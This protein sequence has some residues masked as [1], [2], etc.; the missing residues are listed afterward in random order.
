[1]DAKTFPQEAGIDR[2]AVHY[3]KGCY[4]G[5][6]AMAKIHFR[7]KVNRK[8]VR[9]EASQPLEPGAEILLGDARIGSVTS[10]ASAPNGSFYGLALVK[11]DVPS[12]APVRVGSV[13]ATA[14]D[15]A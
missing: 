5:Q 13:D 3:D 7:G 6:E 15:A 2:V 8:L 10:A 9:L 11:H 14:S 12:G 4:T 1:M